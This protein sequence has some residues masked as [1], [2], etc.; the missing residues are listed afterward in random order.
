MT[1]AAS[2]RETYVSIRVIVLVVFVS[3]FAGIYAGA[4]AAAWLLALGYPLKYSA[5]PASLVAAVTWL[6]AMRQWWMTVKQ[7]EADGFELAANR[8]ADPAADGWAIQPAVDVSDYGPGDGG[9]VQGLAGAGGVC[10]DG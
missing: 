7:L 10:G 9:G 3:L 4:I 6:Y 2:A 1:Y 5:I 8:G